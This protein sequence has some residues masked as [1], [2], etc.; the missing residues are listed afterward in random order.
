M[1]PKPPAYQMY[2]ADFDTDTAEFSNAEVGAYQRLLNSEWINGSLPSDPAK[3]AR[4]AREDLEEFLKL[5]T[6]IGAK[7]HENGN[8]RLYNRRMEEVRAQQAAWREKSS[9]GGKASAEKRKNNQQVSKGSTKDQP[10]D[11]PTEPPNGNT[12]VS[13]FQSSTLTLSLEK[14]GHPAKKPAGPLGKLLDGDPEFK[15]AFDRARVYFPKVGDWFGK[16]FKEY[17]ERA[18]KENRDELLTT[19]RAIAEKKQFDGNP[20]GYATNAFLGI[21]KDRMLGEQ[22]DEKKLRAVHI[23]DL[24][25][26]F[27]PRPTGDGENGRKADRN[28]PKI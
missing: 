19:M 24:Y 10:K 15:T 16:S 6:T 5:W 21:V 23:R 12:S 2:A 4:I 13:G 11:E 14:K 28:L 18:I 25:K 27:K 17:G 22:R 3:L 7:F 8:G 9:K 26:D 1:P 20:W